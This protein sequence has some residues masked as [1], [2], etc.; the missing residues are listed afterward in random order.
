MQFDS[1]RLLRFGKKI[2]SIPTPFKKSLI[3]FGYVNMT[4]RKDYHF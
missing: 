2:G 3:A 1:A 4:D